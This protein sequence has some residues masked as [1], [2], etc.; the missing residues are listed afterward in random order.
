MEYKQCLETGF[1]LTFISL[2]NNYCILTGLCSSGN[3]F[4]G[5]GS[6]PFDSE[7]ILNKKS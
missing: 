2:L 7:I 4:V 6:L 1:F 3:I 5:E